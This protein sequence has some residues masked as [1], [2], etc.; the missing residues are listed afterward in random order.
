MAGRFPSAGGGGGSGISGLT[1][2]VVPIAKTGTTIGDGP[3]TVVPSLH[4]QN[5]VTNVDGGSTNGNGALNMQPSAGS[6]NFG[7]SISFDNQ[8][9]DGSAGGSF[10]WNWINGSSGMGAYQ[11]WFMACISLVRVFLIS[12]DHNFYF[13]D[14]SG[15]FHDS[16]VTIGG[17]LKFTK[18]GQIL[19]T[20]AIGADWSGTPPTSLQT[21]V[22]RLALWIQLNGG[23]PLP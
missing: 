22:D 23:G 21:A 4:P 15:D 2:G 14:D 7:A 9:I 20:P 6:G 10:L 19:Y 5:R 17:H 12:P 13:D 1:A 18:G 16:K 11:K 3:F 8:L